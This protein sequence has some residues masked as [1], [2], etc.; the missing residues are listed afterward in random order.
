MEKPF[1][2]DISEVKTFEKY[3]DVFTQVSYNPETG[4]YLYERVNKEDHDRSHYEVVRGKRYVNPDGKAVMVYPG[5]RD[6]GTY[7][8]TVM[9]TKW[10]EKIIDF[11]MSAKTHSAQEMYEFKKTLKTPSVSCTI[12]TF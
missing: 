10:S 1:R 7:G 8:Y 3:G 2:K 4:W 11:I 12:P 5:E 6:W 9:K